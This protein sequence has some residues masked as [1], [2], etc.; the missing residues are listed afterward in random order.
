MRARATTPDLFSLTSA[1]AASS[2]ANPAAGV[3]RATSNTRLILP[4]DLPNAIKQLEDHEF[5]R[6]LSAVLSEQ[7]RRGKTSGEPNATSHKRPVKTAASSLTAGKANAVRA[8]F[9]AGVSPS[10]IARSFGVSQA[11]VRKALASHAAN[12]RFFS[13][14][15]SFCSS[16]TRFRL[17]AVAM[18]RRSGGT[19][20]II[21][22]RV[23]AI[24]PPSRTETTSSLRSPYFGWLYSGRCQ[25]FSRNFELEYLTLV[26]GA[27]RRWYAVM[28][29]EEQKCMC[30]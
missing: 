19:A 15:I 17:W 5:D 1:R 26:S 12:C 16:A 27:R 9:K 30:Q 2:R 21:S 11:D 8:A 23:V 4:G 6:L 25:A 29:A 14:A 10:Q 7:K 18:A 24:G 3:T 28:H 22:R 13:T 20:A